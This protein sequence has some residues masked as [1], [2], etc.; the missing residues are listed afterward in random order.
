MLS[1]PEFHC[2]RQEPL[3]VEIHELQFNIP[4][5]AGLLISQDKR[6]QI[7]WAVGARF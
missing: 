7:E 4:D 6:R 3:G 1:A 2:L 5:I